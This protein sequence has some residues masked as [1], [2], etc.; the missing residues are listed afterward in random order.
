MDTFCIICIYLLMFF[1]LAKLKYLLV[2]NS[3][4]CS[5][6]ML[7]VF[8]VIQFTISLFSCS[9]LSTIRDFCMSSSKLGKT[10]WIGKK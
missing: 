3:F 7:F 1:T 5:L 8:F 2:E 10:Y 6:R 4:K 9:L